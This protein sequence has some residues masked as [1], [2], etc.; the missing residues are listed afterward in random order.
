MI[1]IIS[2]FRTMV[3]F[4]GVTV[5]G[6]LHRKEKKPNQDAIKMKKYKSGSVI[7]IADGFGSCIYSTIGAGAAV[8][9][10][11]EA[12]RLWSKSKVLKIEY[13]LRMIHLLWEQKI[14]PNAASDCYSTCLFAIVNNDNK[15]F[16]GQL[17]DGLV[18]YFNK[19]NEKMIHLD[20]KSTK[21][22]SNQ[23]TGLGVASKLSEWK[24]IEEE[25]S[26]NFVILLCTDG[27][28]DDIAEGKEND[29]MLYLLDEIKLLSPKKR[30]EFLKTQLIHWSTPK[31][32][33]D[34]T[35]SLMWR[36]Q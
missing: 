31:H 7:A 2:N 29:F 36:N 14:L 9:S 17:G 32:T 28:S 18:M 33:D 11:H 5:K 16:L 34:K 24:F 30:T 20:S 15:L 22:F 13:F 8:S 27:V 4:T 25:V 6:P 3:E 10:V 19:D 12:Y 26:D 23:T 21:A 1:L 35:I